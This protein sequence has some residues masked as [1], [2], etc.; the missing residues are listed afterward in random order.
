M[1]TNDLDINAPISSGYGQ[2]PKVTTTVTTTHPTQTQNYH[3]R[4]VVSEV[5][6]NPLYLCQKII[7]ILLAL[8]TVILLLTLIALA[9][10]GL[11]FLREARKG[12]K[13]IRSGAHKAKVFGTQ[14]S[15]IAKQKFDVLR[16]EGAANLHDA[17]LFI[18]QNA[19]EARA[20][21]HDTKLR[22]KRHINSQNT[23]TW[24]K[25][26]ASKVKRE[27]LPIINT[28]QENGALWAANNAGGAN[29]YAYSAPANSA[30]Q[31]YNVAYAPSALQTNS[32][33]PGL[34]GLV[35]TGGKLA[36]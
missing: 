21:L 2:L 25:T 23:K 12:A 9:F 27:A 1:L 20:V 33:I 15:A 16:K 4:T 13:H 14:Q 18:N 19:P 26:Q 17:K 7:K 10:K 29:P 6:D 31:A 3:Y 30:Y 22:A 24:V 8:L 5:N 32:A 35:A 11:Y 36:A 34:A 28:I